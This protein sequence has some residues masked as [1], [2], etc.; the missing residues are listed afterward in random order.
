MRNP[1][2]IEK[3]RQKQLQST[4]IKL[5]QA[6]KGMRDSVAQGLLRI[7][8]SPEDFVTI[9]DDELIARAIT[10]DELTQLRNEHP[11][12]IEVNLSDNSKR[13][14]SDVADNVLDLNLANLHAVAMAKGNPANQAVITRLY[15]QYDQQRLFLRQLAIPEKQKIKRADTIVQHFFNAVGTVLSNSGIAKPDKLP[16]LIS[17][18]LQEYRSERAQRDHVSI[19]VNS[20]KSII[21]FLDNDAETSAHIQSYRRWYLRD[22]APRLTETAHNYA[23]EVPNFAAITEASVKLNA[24]NTPTISITHIGQSHG[25]LAPAVE[26][27]TKGSTVSTEHRAQT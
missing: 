18:W 4:L 12:G 2:T 26:Y 25:S 23:S 22:D 16:K 13:A 11:F 7:T 14:E 3:T 5:V 6:G 8:I 15:Q 21:N 17:H 27:S 1:I 9:T 20:G 24:T 19:Q 10:R